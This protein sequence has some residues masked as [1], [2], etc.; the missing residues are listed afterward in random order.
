MLLF[1]KIF[2]I[3][4]FIFFCFLLLLVVIVFVIGMLQSFFLEYKQYRFTRKRIN[5]YEK[6]FPWVDV[7]DCL[8]SDVSSDDVLYLVITDGYAGKE[9]NIKFINSFELCRYSKKDGW[10]SDY[11]S[12]TEQLKVKYWMPLPDAPD[13]VIK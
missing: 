13:E 3:V 10:S 9:K 4:F 7:A 5:K 8:H 12:G 1:L 2:S 6:L 11:F